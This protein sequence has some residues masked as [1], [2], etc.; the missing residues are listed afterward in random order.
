MKNIKELLIRVLVA[1]G[2]ILFVVVTF[3]VLPI[4]D[5]QKGNALPL[6]TLA[7]VLILTCIVILR[8]FINKKKGEE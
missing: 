6:V 8:E 3:I 2:V 5:L 7:V 1:V 4:Q